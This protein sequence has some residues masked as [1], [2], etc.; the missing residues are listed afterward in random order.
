MDMNY[1]HDQE[2]LNQSTQKV[3]EERR[4]FLRAGLVG[5]VIAAGTLASVAHAQQQAVAAPALTDKPWWPHPKWGKDD[6]AGASNWITPAKVLE[7]IKVIKD[8][9]IYRVG[10]VYEAA[11]PKFGQRTFN[12]RT[13]PVDGVYGTNRLVGHE[14]FLAA[15][16]A[17]TGTQF[18]GLGHIGIQMG[19]PGDLTETRFYNGFTELD[20]INSYGLK[21]LGIENCKPIFT[22]G[23]LFDVE[24]VKGAPMDAGQEITV[25]DLRAAMQKQNMKEDDIKEGDALFFNTGW[26][27]LWMKNNDKYNS[28]EPGIGLEVAKWVVDKGACMTGGDTWAV[29]VVPNPNKD[30]AFPVHSELI[31]KHGIYNHEN[32]DFTGL[33]ADGKYQFAY[34]FSPAPIKGATGSNGGPIAVT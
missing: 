23:H 8:G 22:R 34:I 25:A 4:A 21:K 31:T 5:G 26:G 3:D 2:G 19:R 1:L 16:V 12:V 20:I 17:Q 14:E 15:E 6:Q 29:E 9:K 24:A 13:T 28:G 10:R 11:M 7:T 33:I 27:K 18:D 30:L 32:L